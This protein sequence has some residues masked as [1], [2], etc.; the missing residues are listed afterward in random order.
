VLENILIPLA[1]FFLSFVVLEDDHCEKWQKYSFKYGIQLEQ[2]TDIFRGHGYHLVPFTNSD[3][4]SD[5]YLKIRNNECYSSEY[6]KLYA[7]GKLQK[8]N[9]CRKTCKFRA[10]SMESLASLNLFIVLDTGEFVGWVS[11]GKLSDKNS[12]GAGIAYMMWQRYSGYKMKCH[13][14]HLLT[15]VLGKVI[16]A[17]ELLKERGVFSADFLYAT[18]HPENIKSTKVLEKNGFSSDGRMSNALWGLRKI[19]KRPLKKCFFKAF[20]CNSKPLLYVPSG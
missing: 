1:F 14:H 5:A 16:S 18:V 9:D 13:R 17:V 6:I 11:V 15:E 3:E 19:Y 8:E 4:D 10:K 7:N 2:L 12:K 20:S